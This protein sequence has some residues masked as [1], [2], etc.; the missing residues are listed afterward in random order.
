[1]V[2][3]VF[4][5]RYPE[6]PAE[7]EAR[8]RRLAAMVKQGVYVVES[9]HL[10]TALLEWDPKRTAPRA[11]DDDSQ[12]RRRAYMREYMRKRRAGR[13]AD[14]DDDTHEPVGAVRAVAN[15][16]TPGVTGLPGP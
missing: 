5:G 16:G 2:T 3:T 7:R 13:G 9:Q 6:S 12:D 10:A 15:T 8:I 1:M 14:D 11:G 4:G